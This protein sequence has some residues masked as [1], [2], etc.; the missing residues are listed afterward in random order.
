[1]P[2]HLADSVAKRALTRRKLNS[3][4]EWV[5][6]G[7]RRAEIIQTGR[8]DLGDLR[9]TADGLAIHPEN[10]ALPVIDDLHTAGAYRLGN[11][12]PIGTSQWRTQKSNSHAIAG[13]RHCELASAKSRQIKT[14]RLGAREE[15]N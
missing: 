14:G 15:T 12:F 9:V 13:R 6:A 8:D 2:R 1:P 7:A 11:D 4:E 5:A 10:D 3:G